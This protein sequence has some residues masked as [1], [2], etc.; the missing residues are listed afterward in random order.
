MNKTAKINFLHKY[1][2]GNATA[3]TKEEKE[4]LKKYKV[5]KNDGFYATK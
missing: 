5:S 1:I 4:L 2:H 3:S